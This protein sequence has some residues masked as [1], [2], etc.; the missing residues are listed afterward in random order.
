M[1]NPSVEKCNQELELELLKVDNT[2]SPVSNTTLQVAVA[3]L[4]SRIRNR[5]LSAKEIVTFR[6][7]VTHQLLPLDD[8]HLTQQQKKVRERNHLA[9][10]KPKYLILI[11]Q[12]GRTSHLAV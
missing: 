10:S 12:L 7:Q 2:G 1:K 3:S 8:K 9:S 4:N 5:G 11:Q 6:D